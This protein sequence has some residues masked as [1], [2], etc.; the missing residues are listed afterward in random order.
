M[1]KLPILTETNNFLEN[2]QNNYSAY[3]INSKDGYFSK[4]TIVTGAI[5]AILPMR[6]STVGKALANSSNNIESQPSGSTALSSFPPTQVDQRISFTLLIN[7]DSWNQSKTQTVPL[8]YTRKGW[9]VQLWGPN[10]DTISSTGRTAVMMTSPTGLDYLHDMSFS[11]LNFLSL[12]GLF[13][14]YMEWKSR[15]IIKHSWDILTI[16]P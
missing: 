15:M 12:H 11:Y 2:Y 9:T 1:P 7:P 4:D 3:R 13:R 8:A 5:P 16:L 6:I 14:W 10:Q